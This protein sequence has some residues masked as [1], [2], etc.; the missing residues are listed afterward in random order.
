MGQICEVCLKREGRELVGGSPWEE[1]S[2]IVCEHCV[3][4]A[5]EAYKKRVVEDII[6][7]KHDDIIYNNLWTRS[8]YDF[9]DNDLALGKYVVD[10]LL[11][12]RQKKIL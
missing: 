4:E 9:P 1:R 7:G 11:T 8:I 12:K 10:E 6:S 2:I 5:V 3:R